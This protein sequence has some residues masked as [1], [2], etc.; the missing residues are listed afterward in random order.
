MINEMESI[1]SNAIKVKENGGVP[2][3]PILIFSSNGQGTGWDEEFWKKNLKRL[4]RKIEFGK[5]V[6]LDCSHYVHNIE[7]EKIVNE[8]KIFIDGLNKKIVI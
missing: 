5:L 6:D 1:K 2:D 3:I 7:Y 4:Y 8:T